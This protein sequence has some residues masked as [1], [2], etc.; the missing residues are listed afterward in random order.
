MIQ[1]LSPATN[2]VGK[3]GWKKLKGFSQMVVKNG[4]ESHGSKELPLLC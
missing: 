3:D 4:D 1:A 2:D